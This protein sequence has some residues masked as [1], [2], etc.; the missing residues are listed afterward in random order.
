MSRPVIACCS[1]AFLVGQ[2]PGTDLVGPASEIFV[3]L[4]QL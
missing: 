2:N 3:I 1:C 4:G